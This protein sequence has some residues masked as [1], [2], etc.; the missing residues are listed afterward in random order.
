MIRHD[1]S[2]PVNLG[3]TTST[4]MVLNLAMIYDPLFLSYS[5]SP[6]FSVF[7]WVGTIYV[8]HFGWG[9]SKRGV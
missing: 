4:L 6:V 3:L 5:L 2:W 9:C 8:L 1:T 7:G